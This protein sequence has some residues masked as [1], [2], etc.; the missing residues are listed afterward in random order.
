MSE[1]MTVTVEARPDT[2]CETRDRRDSEQPKQWH[3]VLLDDDHHSYEYV[4]VMM[5]ELFAM[6]PE[7][8]F[9]VA[10]SV[11]GQGRAVCITTHREHAELK[12]EQVMGY[13]A[14]P[15]I[16]SCQGAMTCVLEPAEFEGDEDGEDR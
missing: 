12:Q 15:L 5:M 14:D 16:A 11:D 4:I 6:P 13:G 7:R 3:V 9:Q 10:Q 1:S 8:A 2:Q